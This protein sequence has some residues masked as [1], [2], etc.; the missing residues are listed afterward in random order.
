MRNLN[1][2]WLG[3]FLGGAIMFGPARSVLAQEADFA[4]QFE[5][6]DQSL[7]A[8]KDLA[9]LYDRSVGSLVIRSA[10]A[11]TGKINTARCV[12]SVHSANWIRVASH[13]VFAKTY[14]VAEA[15]FVL[16]ADPKT[17]YVVDL[18]V[19]PKNQTKIKGDGTDRGNSS[20][21]ILNDYA[22]LRLQKPL[23]KAI[24]MRMC[25][26]SLRPETEKENFLAQTVF[27]GGNTTEYEA[28][29]SVLQP[30]LAGEDIAY[31]TPDQVISDV[32]YGSKDKFQELWTKRGQEFTSPVESRYERGDSG[33]P[34]VLRNYNC[35]IGVTS[36]ISFYRFKNPA[37][38]ESVKI[39]GDF[40]ATVNTDD[41][42]WMDE[43]T[44]KYSPEAQPTEKIDVRQIPV[45]E[46]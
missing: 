27:F 37:S 13:C 40:A 19:I 42:V 22:L 35:Q 31:V 8:A 12:S 1:L 18:A 33:S 11:T 16:G 45:F 29:D 5:N 41:Q 3:L 10:D 23:P 32:E 43:V 34:V 24:P 28:F 15:R 46:H 20:K 44:R 6:N 26:D 9:S 2:H 38:G 36:Y 39:K 4:I 21:D 25:Q 17:P 30:L 14:R 7:S